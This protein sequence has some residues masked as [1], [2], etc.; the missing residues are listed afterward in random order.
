MWHGQPGLRNALAT[1]RRWL[2]LRREIVQPRTIEP[3]NCLL[4]WFSDFGGYPS[5]KSF[6][7]IIDA[8]LG[9]SFFHSLIIILCLI[10]EDFLLEIVS[11]VLFKFF[12]MQFIW[13]SFLWYTKFRYYSNFLII[14][15]YF[16][17]L[18]FNNL[19]IQA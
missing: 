18:L 11:V 14:G 17:I 6:L 12:Y 10:F 3:K 7:L 13:T 16:N 8:Y 4:S 1:W 5:W 2:M 15:H 9:I 19:N